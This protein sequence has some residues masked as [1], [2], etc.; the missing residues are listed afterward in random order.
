MREIRALPIIAL[1]ALGAAVAGWLLSKRDTAVAMPVVAEVAATEAPQPSRSQAG[2][3]AEPTT[4]EP[5]TAK[6]VTTTKP[7]AAKA[8]GHLNF[9]RMDG[10]RETLDLQVAG[11]IALWNPAEHRL[12]VLLTDEA[13]SPSEEQQMLSYLRDERLADSSRPYGV[14]ELQFRPDAT[15]LDRDGLSSA[16][17]TVA[18]AGGVVRDAADVLSSIQWTG[19]VQPSPG[20]GATA[21]SQ[22]QFTAAGSARSADSSPW[23]QNWQLSVAVP[24]IQA[25]E[26]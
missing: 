8:A 14:L 10:S 25:S 22:L 7:A 12:R 21:R 1:A 15:T 18:A 5:T 26:P 19:G 17:L 24:V 9:S 11:G 20:G 6:P 2:A 13:L 3:T 23:Q 4:A 16:S